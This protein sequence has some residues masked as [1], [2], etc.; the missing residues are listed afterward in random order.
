MNVNRYE[1]TDGVL[2][3]SDTDIRRIERK[4]FWALKVIREVHLPETVVYIDD[5]AF[6]K[7]AN[8][9]TVRFAGAFRPGIFG[10]DV[11][12]GCDRLADIAFTDTDRQTEVLLALCANKLAFDQL[13]RS[14]DI[15]Q[16]SWYEKWDIC[17]ATRLKSDDAEAKMSQA[18]CGEEDISY[19]DIGSVDGEMSGEREE[20]LWREGYRKCSLCYVR[21]AND[22]YLGTDTRKIIEDHII[23]NRFGEGNGYSFHAIFEE[24]DSDLSYLRKYL[25]IVKPDRDELAGMTAALMPKDVLARSFLIKESSSLE[26]GLDGLL[27]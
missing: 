23:A 4:A 27:L 25:D 6:G 13:I 5:W 3:L 11:F 26:D 22:R 12:K 9:E 17:L 21:L 14:D 20:Y 7:C 16:K 15:G 10:R 24:C 2:D 18:L 19:D 1:I 8:L